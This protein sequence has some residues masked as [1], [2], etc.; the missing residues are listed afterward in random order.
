MGVI[1]WV[2]SKNWIC[3]TDWSIQNL[4]WYAIELIVFVFLIKNIL[5]PFITA[6]FIAL[7]LLKRNRGVLGQGH[8]TRAA[9]LLLDLWGSDINYDA[10]YTATTG[11]ATAN[12]IAGNICERYLIPLKLAEIYTSTGNQRMLRVVKSFK[13]KIV[14]FFIA[15]LKGVSDG[16]GF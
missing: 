7:K 9:D 6:I 3:L 8:G 11:N 13:N 16:L 10:S 4:L 14:R 12:H 2:I 5:I 1:D 15:R